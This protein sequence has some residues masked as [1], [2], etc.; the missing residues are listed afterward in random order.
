MFSIYDDIGLDSLIRLLL[1]TFCLVYPDMC[2][3]CLSCTFYHQLSMD[4]S[5]NVALTAPTP[6]HSAC[7]AASAP[8]AGK[9]RKVYSFSVC[10]S[11]HLI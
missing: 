9:W 6:P 3:Y 2:Y 4:P 7:R 8:A 5:C 10:H 1:F 11:V